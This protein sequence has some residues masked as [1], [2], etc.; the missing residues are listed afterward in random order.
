M[1]GVDFDKIRNMKFILITFLL[2]V[3]VSE[4]KADSPITSTYFYIAYNEIRQIYL[5]A[6][7]GVLSYESAS[8]LSSPLVSVDKKVAL[9]NALS[10]DVDGKRNKILFEK[11]LKNKY[12]VT[13]L[14]YSKISSDE[15]LCLGY[16]A[17]MDNYFNLREPLTILKSA[18]K[19]N[20]TS[21][22]YNIIYGLVLSQALVGGE[23]STFDEDLIDT[24]FVDTTISAWCNIYTICAKIEAN[25]NL[26]QDFRQSA[27]R[28]IFAYLNEY[29][30]S[31]ESEDLILIPSISHL[32]KLIDTRIKLNS[33]GGVYNIPITINEGIKVSFI[34]DSGASDVSISSDV[35]S[36][37][38]KQ[39]KIDKADILGYETYQIA[40]GSTVKN[41]SILLRKVQ[42]GD[43]VVTNVKASVGNAR[44]PL[45]LG[46]SFLQKF[47][48]FTI[49]NKGGYL[50]IDPKL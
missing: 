22:T 34:F 13:Q 49:D 29:K 45:L 2:A 36:V 1:F 25:K 6:E 40:D 18:L 42:I 31:C 30:G 32:T 24:R 37:L 16:L 47:N 14:D 33:N 9:I 4:C 44:T 10:W 7:E 5:A 27:K 41:L 15:Q 50:I 19:R 12:Q 23:D 17:V 21:Y 39:G 43:I 20:P 38:L 48:Q 3:S 11:F 26:K 46:Q 35:F 28:G 8:F